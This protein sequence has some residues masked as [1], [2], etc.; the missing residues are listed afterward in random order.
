MK[1]V[2]FSN[3]RGMPVSF[4]GAVKVNNRISKQTSV[5]LSLSF[6]K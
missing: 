2:T 3:H 4:F 5:K 6:E 1:S